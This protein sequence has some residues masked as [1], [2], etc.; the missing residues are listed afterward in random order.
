[1]RFVDFQS[2]RLSRLGRRKPGWLRQAVR[3]Q[4]DPHRASDGLSGTNKLLCCLILFA[5]ASAV[6]ETEPTIS[7]PPRGRF[8]RSGTLVWSNLRDGAA[9]ARLERR[10]RGRDDQGGLVVSRQMAVFSSYAL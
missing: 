3:L 9:G 10:R 7:A 6:L 1:M 4:L 2:K 5:V 8:S